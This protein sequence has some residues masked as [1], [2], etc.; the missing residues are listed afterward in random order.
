MPAVG[1]NPIRV[2][3]GEAVRGFPS[4]DGRLVYFVRSVDAPGLWSVP[5]DGGQETLVLPDVRDGFWAVA[6][7]GIFFLTPWRQGST[8]PE[9]LRFFAFATGAV[10][11]LPAPHGGWGNLAP[12]FATPRDGRFVLWT[13]VDTTITDLML[14]DRWTP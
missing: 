10:S 5:V 2:T 13:R 4:P 9:V 14:I 3:T 6:D 12:G 7:S 8:E 11:T 1:G